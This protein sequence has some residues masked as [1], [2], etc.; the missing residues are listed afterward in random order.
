MIYIAV[1][2]LSLHGITLPCY[3]VCC[4]ELAMSFFAILFILMLDGEAGSNETRCD[5]KLIPRT[6]ELVGNFQSPQ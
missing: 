2:S 6:L 1:S 4:R 5:P 3:W